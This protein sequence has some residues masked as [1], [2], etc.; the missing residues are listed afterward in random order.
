VDAPIDLTTT[1]IFGGTG[2]GTVTLNYGISGTVDIVKN[3]PGT[4]RFGTP[5]VSPATGP[6][7]NTCWAG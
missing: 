3:G 2:P 1:T 5:F 4:F 6:S 7:A